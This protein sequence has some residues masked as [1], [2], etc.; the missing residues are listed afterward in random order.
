MVFP[1]HV[2]WHV[3]S[4]VL[5]TVMLWSCWC[6]SSPRSSATLLSSNRISL[7]DSVSNSMS[8]SLGCSMSLLGE[9]L[10]MKSNRGEERNLESKF[11]YQHKINIVMGNVKCGIGKAR[12]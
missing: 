9:L 4:E 10:R 11:I 3:I 12:N 5:A 6:S 7:S 8:I 2:L 1:E